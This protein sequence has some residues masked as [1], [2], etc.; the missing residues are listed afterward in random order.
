[1]YGKRYHCPSTKK[2]WV[3]CFINY[4]ISNHKQT[5]HEQLCSLSDV[6]SQ[7]LVKNSEQFANV[8]ENPLPD[9]S[10]TNKRSRTVREQRI[11]SEHVTWNEEIVNC[12]KKI[13]N[14]LFTNKYANTKPH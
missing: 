4:Q 10:A 1:M 7:I 3:W 12:E 14:E 6:I 11:V 9:R 13:V 5:A 2:T 8:Y